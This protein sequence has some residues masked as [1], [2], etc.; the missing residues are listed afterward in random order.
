MKARV[1]TDICCIKS[2]LFPS[3]IIVY[4]MSTLFITGDETGLLK[5]VDYQ[6][7]TVY[8]F[9]EK[10]ERDFSIIGLAKSFD[11]QSV[12]LLRKNQVIEYWK[13]DFE[14]NNLSF[15]KKHELE[16]YEIS[17]LVDMI[18]I[19][20]SS[21]IASHL[22]VYSS[23]GTINLLR[24]NPELLESDPNKNIDVFNLNGPLS[25]AVGGLDGALL[26]GGRENDVKLYNIHTKQSIWEAR[27]VPHDKLRLRVPVWITSVD[28]FSPLSQHTSEQTTFLTGTAYKQVRIYDTKANNRPVKSLDIEGDYR[29]TVV[30]SSFDG[31]GFYVA[32]TAGNFYYYDYRTYRRINTMKC[33]QGSV[34]S[35]ALAS[36][37]KGGRVV[38]G[39]G[40][41]RTLRVYNCQKG[42]RLLSKIYLKNRLNRCIAFEDISYKSEESNGKNG[43]G[44]DES[45]EDDDEE[46]G[47]DGSEGDEQDNEEDNDVLEDIEFD[48]DNDFGID[49]DANSEDEEDDEEESEEEEDNKKGKGRK[50]Q[51]KGGP[52]K[53][54]R[55]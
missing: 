20:D 8:S 4:Q 53:R 15:E 10:Q 11:E 47:D 33:F 54:Q 9:G 17:D 51:N 22:F 43:K 31:N 13:H 5:A 34:R 18:P 32:D 55:R 6:R 40:L 24:N 37:R 44:D 29:M 50:A 12:A 25:A 21:A 26:Y 16:L 35:V 48:S 28:F 1:L 3:I 14:N 23:N 30:K 2:S 41:D 46:D 49:E 52:N 39:V 38:G 7:Q 36:S 45:D 27:N 42:H 19:Y